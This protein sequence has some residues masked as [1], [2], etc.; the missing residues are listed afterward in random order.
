MSVLG[1]KYQNRVIGEW[2]AIDR[3]ISAISWGSISDRFLEGIFMVAQKSTAV[4]RLIWPQGGFNCSKQN[5]LAT[6]SSIRPSCKLCS[7]SHSRETYETNCNWLHPI[8]P[9]LKRPDR[10]KTIDVAS[11][12]STRRFLHAQSFSVQ[13]ASISWKVLSRYQRVKI[14]GEE[15]HWI[16]GFG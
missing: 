14:A 7:L 2:L 6:K 5:L 4:G 10:H 11:K 12:T 9:P 3:D 15:S 1:Y 16:S 8:W 13:T